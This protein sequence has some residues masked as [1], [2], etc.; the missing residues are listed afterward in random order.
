MN[1]DRN[2]DAAG[3][4]QGAVQ[5]RAEGGVSVTQRVL[6]VKGIKCVPQPRGGYLKVKDMLAD[7]FD[8]GKDLTDLKSENRHPSAVGLAV[9]YLSRFVQGGD[10]A[11]AFSIPILAGRFVQ[12]QALQASIQGDGE[13]MLF[14]E[15]YRKAADRIP[16][17]LDG[18][19]GLDDGSIASA[20]KLAAYD[21]L[22]RSNPR[23]FVDPEAMPPANEAVIEH[24]RGM[25]ERSK[26]F[27]DRY[28]P[29]VNG[30]DTFEG[31]YTDVVSSGDC[32]L[33]TDHGL[34]DFKCS[35]RPPTSKHTLQIL[36]Y[37]QLGVHSTHPEYLRVEEIGIW[38]PRLN[39]AWHQ[40]AAGIPPEVV[41]EVCRKVLAYPD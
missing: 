15:P 10:R 33:V 39:R 1:G 31:G 40:D 36:M 27:I 13:G 23:T 18:V 28:G 21:C 2:G 34:W 30:L 6:G 3:P 17:Y 4:D 32:D 35:V 5:A 20:F 19:T 11:D 25:V 24:T 41:D 22:L 9:D 38:N 8:D 14:W 16:E 37:W 12:A 26:A 7:E 29:A